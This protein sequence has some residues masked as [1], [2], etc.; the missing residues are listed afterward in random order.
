MSVKEEFISECIKNRTYL[1][2]SYKD[3]ANCLIDVSESDYKS[4]ENGEYKISKE[5]VARLI[6]VLCIEKSQDEVMELD[7]SDGEFS[8]EEKEDLLKIANELVGGLDD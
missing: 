5:N 4:F 8:D 2:L 6:R 1:G 7:L 3:M